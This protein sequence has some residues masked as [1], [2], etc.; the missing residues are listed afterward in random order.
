VTAFPL[1]LFFASGYVCG[2]A[3]AAAAMVGSLVRLMLYGKRK[4]TAWFICCVALNSVIM[5]VGLTFIFGILVIGD[6]DERAHFLF[7]AA[8]F[9]A[10]LILS[11]CL[12]IYAS[13]LIA[14]YPGL[15]AWN[16]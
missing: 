1:I 2:I 7:K 5:V 16:N 14:R 11:G 4:V 10:G 15:A 9:S 8:S 12:V 6:P 13:K 3:L